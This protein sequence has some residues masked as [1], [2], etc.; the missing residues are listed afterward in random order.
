MVVSEKSRSSRS[1]ITWPRKPVTPVRKMRLPAR[2]STMLVPAG[3]LSTTR[4]IIGY[5]PAG[6]Q[7]GPRIAGAVGLSLAPLQPIRRE[8]AS[9]RRQD[10]P[11]APPAHS[12]SERPPLERHGLAGPPPARQERA[13]AQVR[14]RP[15]P[16]VDPAA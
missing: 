14:H 3:R 15:T 1:R 13:F 10:P 5:L 9:S 6:R 11:A 7:E 4:Q 2:A 16:V 8:G 12:N